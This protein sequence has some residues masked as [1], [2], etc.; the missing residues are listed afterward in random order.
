MNA[1][2][3]TNVEHAR[4]WAGEVPAQDFLRPQELELAE[5]FGYAGFLLVGLVV[6]DNRV[7]SGLHRSNGTPASSA[8][9]VEL[10]RCLPASGPDP[11]PRPSALGPAPAPALALRDAPRRAPRGRPPSARVSKLRR[12]PMPDMAQ[13]PSSSPGGIGPAGLNRVLQLV[14]RVEDY[15][16]AGVHP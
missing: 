7:V 14:A 9:S 5:A 6:A 12:G 4:R 3:A 13:L 16:V 11:G 2:P 10:A 1:R 15:D 8:T